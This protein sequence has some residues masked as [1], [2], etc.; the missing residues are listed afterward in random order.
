MFVI[1]FSSS[2]CS[3]HSLKLLLVF[4]FQVVAIIKVQNQSLEM[5][6]NLGLPLLL[7]IYLSSARLVARI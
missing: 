5:T 4:F 2:N 7:Q 3:A 6:S 1:S